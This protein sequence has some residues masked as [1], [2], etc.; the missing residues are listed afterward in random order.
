[1][2]KDLSDLEG[3]VMVPNE[4]DE[5][6]LKNLPLDQKIADSSVINSSKAEAAADNLVVDGSPTHRRYSSP[7]FQQLLGLPVEPVK[8]LKPTIPE[9]KSINNLLHA[10]S[11]VSKT[12][13]KPETE[14]KA[15]EDEH[16]KLTP[17]NNINDVSSDEAVD[18]HFLNE[19]SVTEKRPSVQDPEQVLM[20]NVVP[21]ETSFN[22]S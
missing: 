9:D 3:W 20:R 4:D 19:F 10:A 22:D 13:K 14:I 5:K 2:T 21:G 8:I 16:I 12:Q 7:L 17:I 18:E 15:R 1:M 11:L 6:Q